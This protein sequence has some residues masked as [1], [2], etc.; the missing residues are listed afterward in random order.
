MK[1][2][3]RRKKDKF[4]IESKVNGRTLFLKTLPDPEE[5]LELLV[6]EPSKIYME[7]KLANMKIP[8]PN[9]KRLTNQSLKVRK[10]S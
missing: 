10:T 3:I 7:R 8:S 1:L 5:L 9:P 4:V 2:Y 6:R